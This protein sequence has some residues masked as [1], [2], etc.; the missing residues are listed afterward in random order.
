[1]RS[2]TLFFP[3]FIRE[4]IN[5]ATSTLWNLGSGSTCLFTVFRRRDIESYFC[6]PKLWFIRLSGAVLRS[7]LPAFFHPACVQ[8]ASDDV[9]SNP[10]TILDASAPDQNDRM[11]LKIVA[12]TGNIGRNFNP[13]GQSHPGHLA[14]RRIGFSGSTCVDA[15]ANPAALRTS[16]QLGGV[17]LLVVF[18]PALSD[19]LADCRQGLYPFQNRENRENN[20]LKI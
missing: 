1:M 20:K 12:F 13:R 14:Q 4:L 6:N 10:W 16:F 11:L 18:P 19:Q 9:I 2:A 15:G 17:A 8:N 3:F 5:R 7:P